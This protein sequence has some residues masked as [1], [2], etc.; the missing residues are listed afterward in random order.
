MLPTSRGAV[1]IV[2]ALVLY[3]VAYQS[4][5]GWYYL[6]DAGL[7]GLLLVNVPYPWWSL[8]RLTATRRMTALGRPRALGPFEGETVRVALQVENRG[9][10]PRWLVQVR[11]QCPLE[12]PGQESRR[13]LLGVVG[14]RTRL[15]F[16][17]D[18]LCHRR[19]EYR[20]GPLRLESSAPFGLFR[21]RRE[22]SAPLKVL[23]Y[24]E[25]FPFTG[26]LPGGIPQE[27]PAPAAMSR[28]PGEFRGAR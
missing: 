4:H 28:S 2:A 17:Y 26:A 12:A 6:A 13:Y 9:L 16:F 22:V 25:V 5:V 8:R 10:L 15:E 24:P 23:V 1:L 14:A 11:E 7:W 3:L 21:A 18:A 19:G 27:G 20:I